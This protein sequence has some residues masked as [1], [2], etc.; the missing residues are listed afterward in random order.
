MSAKEELQ[1][2]VSAL[3]DYECSHLLSVVHE[4]AVG[5]RFWEG[6]IGILYNEYV[7]ARYFNISRNLS[8]VIPAG[9]AGDEGIFVPIPIV[10]SYPN[11][12]KI[13]LPT[14]EPVTT[15]YSRT[16]LSRRSRRDFGDDP[17]TLSQLST[18]LLHAC[19]VTL[20]VEGYDYTRLPLRSFPS[21]GGLQAPE[22]YLSVQ[23][24]KD[25]LPGLYHYQPIDHV[26]EL[27]K[28]GS[29]GETLRNLALGQPFVETASVVFV[30]TGYYDRL[31]WKYG[32]RSYRYMCIDTGFLGQNL[33]LAAEAMGLGACAIAGFIDDAAE[34]F[35]DVDGKSEIVLLLVALG[36]LPVVEGLPRNSV[37]E[38]A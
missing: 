37:N 25:L 33:Y 5:E 8:N 10:K 27:L 18:L 7:K 19:G 23:R 3:S 12:R 6:D 31:R 17:L 21:S 30:L 34:K 20:F 36:T 38:K 14:P 13:A 2:L 22:V 24:V 16:V 29:Y 15:D 35:L 26:L 28:E 32:E 1:R 9:P 4:V 11:A